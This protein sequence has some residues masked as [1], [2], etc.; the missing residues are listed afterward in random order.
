M[1]YLNNYVSPPS[2]PIDSYHST[3]P[4]STYDQN[5]IFPVPSCLSSSSRNGVKLF[6]IVPSIHLEPLFQLFSPFPDSFKWLPYGPFP[7]YPEFLTFWESVVRRDPGTLLFVVYDLSL[8]FDN[9]DG[10]EEDFEKE[11][12]AGM[13][14]ERIAGIVGVLKS[15]EQNRSSEIGHL[16]IPPPFQRT[17]VLTHS[18]SA[19]LHW[20]L[21]PPSPSTRESLGLRRVQWFANALNVPSINAALRMGFTKESDCMRWERITKPSKEGLPLPD[22]LESDPERKEEEKRRGGGRHSAVLGL[23]WEAWE[24]GGREKVKGLL[25]REVKPRDVKEVNFGREVRN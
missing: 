6:P 22:F 8:R 13:R 1:P 17:H 4:L 20:L 25:E 14:K 21:D 10:E 3:T 19:L 18:I 15:N 11:G 16:H 9:E 5:F 23:D 24:E 2:L 7:T 12:G